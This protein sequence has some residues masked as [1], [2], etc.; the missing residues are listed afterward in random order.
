VQAKTENPPTKLLARIVVLAAI[1]EMRIRIGV[2]K[3]NASINEE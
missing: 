1:L 2:G 3:V